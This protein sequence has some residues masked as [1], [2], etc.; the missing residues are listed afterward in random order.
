MTPNPKTPPVGAEC[1]EGDV[2]ESY[3]WARYRNSPDWEPVLVSGQIVRCI[4][5][6]AYCYPE[7][8]E[9]GEKIARLHP[10]SIATGSV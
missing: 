4:G 10:P 5:S 8:F 7:E 6:D 2:R 3:H 9:I 1:P